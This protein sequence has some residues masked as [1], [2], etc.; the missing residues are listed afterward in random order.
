MGVN[1]TLNSTTP[2]QVMS[3]P[4]DAQVDPIPIT[5]SNLPPYSIVQ[6]TAFLSTQFGSVVSP[7]ATF[8]TAQSIPPALAPPRLK[9]LVVEADHAVLQLTWATPNPLPGI[10]LYYEVAD[11]VGRQMWK[12]AGTEC[13][14]SLD[15]SAALSGSTTKHPQSQSGDSLA[16]YFS[17]LALRIRAATSA[18]IGPWSAPISLSS[19]LIPTT[20]GIISLLP[21]PPSPP[22]SA[23]G[24]S[25]SSSSL[26]PFM[27]IIIVAV[28]VAVL[29]AVV[30]GFALIT[31]ARRRK[32]HDCDSMEPDAVFERMKATIPAEIVKALESLHSGHRKVPRQ[33][34]VQHIFPLELLGEGKFGTVH[35][36]LLDE[37]EVNQIPG[38]LVAI[39]TSK[40]EIDEEHR[41]E[42]LMEAV[43]M[44]QFSHNNIVNLIGHAIDHETGAIVLVSQFCEH[45]C[46]ASYLQMNDSDDIHY[47]LL[48]F[49]CDIATGMEYIASL[50]FVHRDLAVS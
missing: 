30:V 26:S 37:S 50:G 23:A 6:V 10:I 42:M 7:M 3:V 33:I 20:P 9:L 17:A 21:Q 8:E 22:L 39:K 1:D 38:Y 40:A 11:G 24:T 29:V 19:D 46:L 5:I 12:G 14:I 31:R 41:H 13:N 25:S 4:L 28:A 2:L 35:K 16:R 34:D 36:G 27:T 49:A 15:M 47:L 45:G 48:D 44:A 43:I 18:G 32:Q